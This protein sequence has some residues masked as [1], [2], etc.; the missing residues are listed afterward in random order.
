MKLCTMASHGYPHGL[1][2]VFPEQTYCKVS[3]DIPNFLPY[4][5]SN[6]ELVNSQSFNLNLQQK[7]DWKSTG[8]VSDYDQFV[9]FDPT[10]ARIDVQDSNPDTNLL[11]LGIAERYARHEEILK[12]LASRSVEEDGLLD[13]SML[14]DF[15][16]PQDSLIYP[17][18]EFYLNEPL[19]NLSGDM[20]G[21]EMQDV[22]SAISHLQMSKNAINSSKLAMLVPYFEWRKK[23]R[24]STSKTATAE[25][26]QLK[27][28]EKVKKQPLKKKTSTTKGR[29]IYGDS[30]LHACESLLSV[31]VGRNHQVQ[32][33]ILS[34]KK[35]GP[36]LPQLLIQ[37]SASIAGTGIALVLSVVGRVACSRVPFCA[38]KA[39]STGLGLGL[40][41]LSWAVNKLRDTVISI[42]KTAGNEREDEMMNKLDRN[43][44]DIYFRVAA[45]MVI[46]VLRLA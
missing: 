18:K 26:G 43:L 4:H 2:V 8:V 34:L 14:Y 39:W 5:G 44:K 41:W 6:K 42:S 30:Y 10:S 3:K 7:E 17:T 9:N 29:D 11:S 40:V 35:S 33:P 19:L 25:I 16:G 15:V 13:L 27:S 24:A 46:A 22:L 45:I 38:S 37:F 12:L 31:I 20:N 32:N 36:Q 28:H 21:T 1:G 23:A